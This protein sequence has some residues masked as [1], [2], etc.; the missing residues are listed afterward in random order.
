MSCPSLRALL[1]AGRDEVVAV[2]TQPDRPQGRNLRVQPSPVRAVA[3]EAGIPALTPERLNA[4]DS[5]A[6]LR[7]LRPDVVAVVAYGQILR[8]E[9]LA[10]P[11]KGCLNIHASLLP[12]YRGAAPI[13]WAIVNGAHT[14]GVTAMFMNERLDAGDIVRQ[15]PVPIA[16]DDTAGT[17]HD[18]LAEEGARLLVEIMDAL[19]EG[20]LSRAPQAELEAT[21]APKL[22]K[23]DGR[24]DWTRPARDIHNRVRG[25]TPWPGCF[26]GEAQGAGRKLRVLRTRVEAG[27][28]APGEVLS[29][30][31]EGPLVATGDQALCLIEVQPEG[32]KA[33][34]GEAYLR[35]H[36]LRQGE[37]LG[38]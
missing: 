3:R 4:P 33:M 26:C 18:R 7:A 20:P 23:E 14:T 34:S 35:G 13:Q 22:R 19:R 37:R 15:A 36:P 9:I 10:L 28:G 38:S 17:L 29:L 27:I 8:P 24:I 32:R 16:A 12:K 30:A 31:G 1:A 25:F 6:A 11:P 2:V 21:Y 5:V